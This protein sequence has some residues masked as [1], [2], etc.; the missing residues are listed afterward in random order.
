MNNLNDTSP[1]IPVSVL[2]SAKKVSKAPTGALVGTSAVLV[3]LVELAR[4]GA[5]QQ[6]KDALSP[7]FNWGP[8]LL[9]ILGFLWL[10]HNYAPPLIQSQNDTARALQK[11]ADSV[12]HN[13]SS[14]HDLVLAMQVNSDKLEQL[15]GT[16]SDLQTAV[17]QIKEDWHDARK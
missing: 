3:L 6:Y 13:D 2:D 10:A 1:L 17:H 4:S 14:S 8:G 9:I 15:R 11:L 5:L 7:L 12:A 16:V